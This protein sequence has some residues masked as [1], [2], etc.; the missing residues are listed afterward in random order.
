MAVVGWI[1]LLA[2]GYFGVN[3]GQSGK[4]WFCLLSPACLNMSVQTL[5][6]YEGS[7]LGIQW[8]NINDLYED[9]SFSTA[10][11]MFYVDYIVYMILALYLDH[12]WPSRYGSHKVPWFCFLKS[13][14]KPDSITESLEQ[15]LESADA[16]QKNRFNGTDIDKETFENIGGKYKNVQPSI[17][18]RNLVKYYQGNLSG[19]SGSIVKAV[20]GISLD[21]YRGEVFVLLGHNGKLYGTF[22]IL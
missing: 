9:L 14:W 1:V 18:I 3:F 10:I 7:T 20:N 13:F 4:S 12:V 16:S 2:S 6:Q 8:E 11:V 17:S 22:R 21:I 19:L 5:V 15:E